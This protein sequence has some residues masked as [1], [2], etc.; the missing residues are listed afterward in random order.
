MGCAQLQNNEIQLLPYSLGELTVLTELVLQGN[1]GCKRPPTYMHGNS[2]KELVEFLAAEGGS[3]SRSGTDDYSQ[4]ARLHDE[5]RQAKDDALR[6]GRQEEDERLA[7]THTLA[8]ARQH[9][10]EDAVVRTELTVRGEASSLTQESRL[11]NS[12][13]SPEVEREAVAEEISLAMAG[14]EAYTSELR[15]RNLTGAE[16]MAEEAAI[17][18]RAVSSS[19][20]RAHSDDMMIMREEEAEAALVQEM[21]QERRRAAAELEAELQREYCR[22]VNEYQAMERDARRQM[23]QDQQC[24][25]LSQHTDISSHHSP[26]LPCATPD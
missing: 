8:L 6:Q 12:I 9:S 17:A 16:A 10:Q 5:R 7:T 25:A 22:E 11:V 24:V 1:M 18:A 2:A 3:R 21:K 26:A 23:Q 15:A 14:R 19:I 20:A 13:T 4:V